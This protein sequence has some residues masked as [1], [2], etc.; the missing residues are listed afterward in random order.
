MSASK[1]PVN[2]E[3]MEKISQWIDGHR[4]QITADILRLVKIISVSDPHS[5][6]KPFGKPCREVLEEMMKIGREH[7]FQ[8]E[9]YDYYCGSMWREKS[10]G[11]VE[12]SIGFWGHVDVVPLGDNW[13][14]SPYEPFEKDGYIV[15]RGSQDNKGPTIG[16]MYCIQCLDELGIELKH[17]LRM[18]F[19]CD[20]ERGMTDMEYYAENYPCPKMSIIADCGFPVCYGEKGIIET[21][22]VSDEP[23]SEDVLSLSGGVASNMVPDFAEIVLK[24]TDR[25][26]GALELLPKEI[27]VEEKED[28]YRLTARG[29]SRHTAFPDGGVSAIARLAKGLLYA[30]ALSD[31]DA[32]K[33]M[34]LCEAG[35]DFY[36]RGLQIQCSD[37]ISGRLSCVESMFGQKEDGRLWMHFNIRYPIE[38]DSEKIVE[39]I[40]QSARRRGFSQ[41]LIR[42][43]KPNYFDRN[44]P[45]V[46]LLTG[47]FNE[48]AGMET[49]PYVMAGGTYA[50]KLPRAFAFGMGIPGEGLEHPMFLP[51]HGGGHEP[52]E[53]LRLESLF[54]AM[55]IF[56]M[57]LIALN[58]VEI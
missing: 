2:G 12:E 46:D 19:G 25:V 49:E 3:S 20:E 22:L 40:G 43:S 5:E 57:G 48:I 30:G 14:F 33:F 13:Q 58:D 54:K 28:S 6:V 9:N 11:P 37:E 53:G 7:G 21:N 35:Q 56:C 18:F 38:A 41:E 8:T 47:V 10:G 31:E 45:A 51:G 55:K 1:T 52:D 26:K 24:K 29:I 39:A 15:G 34:Y 4:E 50:R 36:G 23:L 16:T 17:P 27:A 44:H 42:D 32:E